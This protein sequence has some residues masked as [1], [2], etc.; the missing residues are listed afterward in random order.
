MRGCGT[1]RKPVPDIAFAHPGY[2]SSPDLSGLQKSNRKSPTSS[3]TKRSFSLRR[4]GAAISSA[5]SR[6]GLGRKYQHT[7]GHDFNGLDQGAAGFS[8]RL[9]KFPSRHLL[10]ELSEEARGCLIHFPERR[11]SIPRALC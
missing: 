4:I 6:Q 5:P 9:G 1:F 11:P 7:R 8:P 2:A 10:G 3:L